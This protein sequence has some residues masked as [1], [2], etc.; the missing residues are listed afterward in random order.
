[1]DGYWVRLCVCGDAS[2]PR[3]GTDT[4]CGAPDTQIVCRARWL[5][6]RTLIRRLDNTVKMS[7]VPF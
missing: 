4:R 1:M 5:V 7:L 3:S 6:P 2:A